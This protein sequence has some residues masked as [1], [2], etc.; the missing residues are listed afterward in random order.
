MKAAK[1]LVFSAYFYF[2]TRRDENRKVC[3][4]TLE[5]KIE[6]L[7]RYR[8]QFTVERGECGQREG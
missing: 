6:D 4:K 7:G 5:Q 1:N 8:G 2:L 3:W